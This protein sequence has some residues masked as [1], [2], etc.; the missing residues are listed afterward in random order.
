KLFSSLGRLLSIACALFC[1]VFGLSRCF[2]LAAAE[3]LLELVCR[4]TRKHELVVIEQIVDIQT[5]AVDHF[6]VAQVARRQQKVLV[7][8]RIDDQRL[9][10]ESELRQREG[11]VF[12][13]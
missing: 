8:E 12:S 9:A 13:L 3:Q 10:A 1:S 2:A 7:I 6:R 5:E 4:F 11:K